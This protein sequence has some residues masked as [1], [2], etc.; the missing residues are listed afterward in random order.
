M[1]EEDLVI[2]EAL[3]TLYK[4]R[5]PLTCDDFRA[6]SIASR[7]K[8]RSRP[9]IFVSNWVLERFWEAKME[10]QIEFLH[11]FLRC[12]FRVRF[13]IVLECIFGGSEPQKTGFRLRGVLI[14]T[15]S[16]FS[17]NHSKKLHFG[18]V[19]GGQNHQ[20]SMTN[21]VRNYHFF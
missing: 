9:Y 11:V 4:R 15:K 10:P 18:S 14:F 8:L 12:F 5:S 2:C 16:A 7:N 3:W 20:K 1:D 19:W 21:R 6:I 17:K 13:G